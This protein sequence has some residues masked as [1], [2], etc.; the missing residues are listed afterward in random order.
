MKLFV[1]KIIIYIVLFNGL[2]LAA[3]N[4]TTYIKAED[5]DDFVYLTFGFQPD[6]TDDV[7]EG[8]D[9]EAPDPPD[10]GFDAALEWDSDRYFTNILAGDG[11]ESLHSM[12]IRFQ[13]P[14]S[15]Q[16]TLTWDN[17][18]LADFGSFIL[19]DIL[20]GFFVN[21]DMTTTSSFTANNPT[22]HNPLVLM[23]TPNSD[24]VSTNR[25]P[26]AHAGTDMST[27]AGL[28]VELDGS[29]SYDPDLDELSYSWTPLNEVELSDESIINPTF[30]APDSEGSYPFSLTVTDPD[31]LVSDP[32]TVIV[33]VILNQPPVAVAGDDEEVDQ[34]NTVM[35]DGSNSYDETDLGVLYYSWNSL[36]AVTLS[37]STDERPTFFAEDVD[38]VTNYRFELIVSDGSLSSEPDTVTF[39]ILENAAPTAD[40]GADREVDQGTTVELNGAASSDPNNDELTYYWT[41]QDSTIL[42]SDVNAAKPEFLAPDVDEVTDFIFS[43]YVMDEDSLTSESDEMTVTV[44]ENKPPDADAGI[45]LG[46]LNG[47]KLTSGISQVDQGTAVK[48]SGSDSEDINNDGF[49]FEW[50]V[51]EGIFGD[52]VATLSDTNVVFIAPDVD[53]E[54]DF[55]FSLSVTDDHG[56]VSDPSEVTLTVLGN[57]PPTA[58]GGVDKKGYRGSEITLFANQSYDHNFDSLFFDWDVPE[59]IQISDTNEMNPLLSLPVDS[60]DTDYLITLTVFD[61]N[62]EA[63]GLDSVIVT[64]IANSNSKPD[65]PLL[66]ATVEHGKI[67]L[68]WDNSAENSEDAFTG[69]FDFEGYRLYR[70]TDGGVTWGEPEDMLFD[71]EG[72]FVGWKPIVQYDLTAEQDSLHC[73]YSNT[74]DDC[75]YIRGMNFSGIDPMAERIDLGSNSGLQYTYIDSNVV[76]GVEYTYTVTSYDTGLRT[77]E[78]DYFLLEDYGVYQDTIIWSVSNPGYFVGDNEGGIVSQECDF[79]TDNNSEDISDWDSNYVKAVPGY[80]ASNI[81]FPDEEDVT[82]FIIADSLTIGNGNR[83]FTIVNEMEL[84]DDMVKFEVQAVDNPD[85]EIDPFE[86]FK[87]ENPELYVYNIT[88]EVSQEPETWGNVYDVDEY[89]DI[90]IDSLMDFPGAYYDS[91]TLKIKIPDYKFDPIVL[92]YLDDVGFENNW[93]PFFDGIRVRFD[94]ATREYPTDKLVALSEINFNGANAEMLESLF[95]N[96]LFILELKYTDSQETF[97]RRPSYSYLIEFSDQPLDT[98]VEMIPA[99]ACGDRGFNTLLPF[100]ITNITTGKKVG[101]KHTDKGLGGTPGSPGYKDC[102]WTRDETISFFFDEVTSR[103]NPEPTA[104]YTF[105]ITVDFELFILETGL[106]EDWI[107]DASYLEDSVVKHEGMVWYSQ[108]FAQAGI[109]PN[110]WIDND[111]NG[112]NENPWVPV[113][114]WTNTTDDNSEVDEVTIVPVRWYVDGDSWIADLEELGKYSAVTEESLEEITVVPNPYIV[115]SQ[116]NETAGSHKMRFTHLPQVCEITIYTITG[117]EV[118][119]IYH[120]DQYES[121]EWWDLKNHSGNEI[122]PG[123]YFYR[124]TSEGKERLGKFAVVR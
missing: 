67:T 34:G 19:Q 112:I 16:V 22:L 64:S 71:F 107:E 49:E 78:V 92:Q 104:E 45:A 54:T 82:S 32:D 119:V 9:I 113:Y 103:D 56:A 37:D 93:S 58:N 29:Q 106:T 99:D 105:D 85:P 69:Y 25:T 41:A 36:D 44:L 47:V 88:D 87:T 31:G 50:T 80:R 48:L 66:F 120:D 96:E 40:A 39:T 8:L 84:S 7:D 60:I 30:T 4:F 108:A 20:G 86:G 10:T 2:F 98:V 83:V 81:T 43:L 72:N 111:G 52:T 118:D 101:L 74:F 26:F 68:N 110:A 115:R 35:L 15:G 100:R 27:I 33:T 79:G 102:I 94:N 73:I 14:E 57:K 24:A 46:Y 42:L 77:Y 17:T 12:N 61:E 59:D 114:P 90:E 122:A 21:I 11:D 3:Q 95:L 63:S 1:R 70:S 28:T 38:V 5:G 75:E 6:A 55:T 62:G 109:E 18:N 53:T 124:V 76:D 123:L 121:N 13:F 89:T 117:E 23:V 51:P 65:K 97:K 116:F 91:T